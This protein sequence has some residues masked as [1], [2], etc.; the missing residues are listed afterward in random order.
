[1]AD[2]AP[3]QEPSVANRTGNHDEYSAR[4]AEYPQIRSV[5]WDS[6]G[7]LP[8]VEVSQTPCPDID[9]QPSQQ[10]NYQCRLRHIHW[11]AADGQRW[12]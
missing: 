4:V 7:H 9:G 3:P 2:L 10:A 12:S 1:L 8:W 6:P 5:A 11:G